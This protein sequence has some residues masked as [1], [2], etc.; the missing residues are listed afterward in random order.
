MAWVVNKAFPGEPVDPPYKH[1]NRT[2]GAKP[3]GVLAPLYAGERV[4]DTAGGV[5]YMALG[6]TSGTWVESG[7]IG[8]D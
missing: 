6:T 1:Y 7:P 8:P 5:Q 4:L 2:T 3:L